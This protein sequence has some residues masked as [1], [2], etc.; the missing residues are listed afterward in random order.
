MNLLIKDKIYFPNLNGLRFL[1]VLLVIVPH[2]EQHRLWLGMYNY[3]DKFKFIGIMGKLGVVLFFVLSGFLITYLLLSEEHVF[4]TINIRK[5]YVRR[6]LRIWP[7]YFLIVIVG[8]AVLPNIS[9]F[10]LKT[11]EKDVIFND[12][13]LKLML[14]LVFLPNLAL[15]LLGKIPYISHTWSI[16]T[17]EQFYILWPLII[18]YF[19]KNRLITMVL[20]IIIYVL[21][22]FLFRSSWFIS[23]FNTKIIARFWEKF[24]ID[25]MSIG[26][27][28][29]YLLFKKSK[30]LKLLMNVYFFYFTLIITIIFLFIGL[31]IPYIQFEI[32]AILFGIIILNFAANPK[33]KLSLESPVLVY[34]GRI[35]YGLYMYHPIA[36]VFILYI[37]KTNGL[38]FDWLIYP[39]SLLMTI[40][41][42]SL[43]YKYFETFF[44]KSKERF[45]RVLSGV[46]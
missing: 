40:L 43:S 31:K 13:E 17:E 36:I 46:K 27:I 22:L 2:I 15:P 42:S 30:L 9:L 12:I 33:I 5:F 34:L 18:K 45:S 28:I 39:L 23:I 37:L 20:L 25:C 38:E 4:K 44:L 1:A 3:C 14:Y 24:N 16:G 7:L 11:F 8:F 26:G 6:F 29:A 10:T 19:K 35:S 21:L 32:F 41:L